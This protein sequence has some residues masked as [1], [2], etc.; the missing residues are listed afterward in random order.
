MIW[1]DPIS[2]RDP[3]GPLHWTRTLAGAL[4]FCSLALLAAEAWLVTRTRIEASRAQRDNVI[5]VVASLEVDRLNLAL[6]TSQTLIPGAGVAAAMKR[7]SDHIDIYY[8]RVQ[9]VEALL[10]GL[11][12]QMSDPVQIAELRSRIRAEADDIAAE[13]DSGKLS[14]A[15][16]RM[17]FLTRLEAGAPPVHELS[18]AVLMYSVSLAAA[19]RIEN[20]QR[21]TQILALT[22]VLTMLL[23]AIAVFY[24][25]LFRLSRR[26][27]DEIYAAGMLLHK[28]IEASSDAIVLSD[29]A[30]GIHRINR[31]AAEMFGFEPLAGPARNVRDFLPLPTRARVAAGAMEYP[32]RLGHLRVRLIGTG[33]RPFLADVKTVAETDAHG[34][35]LFIFF[36]RDLTETLRQRAHNRRDRQMNALEAHRKLSLFAAVTHELRTP[37][38]VTLSALDLISGEGL[39]PEDR[40]HLDLARQA[41]ILA[42]ARIEETI[43]A[44]S[45]AGAAGEVAETFDPAGLARAVLKA[46]AARAA[47]GNHRL[48][49][50]SACIL[51]ARGDARHFA[52]ALS[53]LLAWALKAAPSGARITIRLSPHAGATVAVAIAV[54]AGDWATAPGAGA[55]QGDLQR[56]RLAVETLH[57]RLVCRPAPA[58]ARFLLPLA[59]PQTAP[60][61]AGPMKV[62]VVDDSRDAAHVAARLLQRLGHDA[63][64]CHDGATAVARAART[65]FD[66]ILMDV[67]MPGMDGLEAVRRIRAGGASSGARMLILSANIL[68]EERPRALALG[69]DRILL[70]PVRPDVLADAL[71]AG[72]TPAEPA[73]DQALATLAEV[74]DPA[75]LARMLAEFGDEIA[76]ILSP[77]PAGR[78]ADALA[79]QVHRCA[80]SA[81]VLGFGDLHAA[82]CAYELALMR[83][84]SDGPAEIRRARRR[85]VARAGRAQAVL[86]RVA[87][88]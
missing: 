13:F 63:E 59:Q 22:A 4:I 87:E 75:S 58:G 80:G 88:D 25:Q 45:P 3:P 7:L 12:D 26:R 24:R 38:Q 70:K 78:S 43:T 29:S 42:V 49:L 66:A 14:G 82:C 61:A 8:S 56:A 18:N 54:E 35:R 86:R 36:I 30:G 53:H 84:D 73:H 10:R 74:L 77:D 27:E 37:M 83:A 85:F 31:R 79:R 67:S 1:R 76:V 55:G 19:Q 11:Q 52:T 16:Q 23:L 41:G 62:L 69:V 60:A 68:P 46:A 17:D 72:D 33:G 5:W 39:S 51:P 34:R 20:E 65:Q 40:E 81:A 32:A 64:E 15:A 44:A 48:V 71:N 47:A 21:V 9:T 50:L 6:T 28:S 57:S 2:R